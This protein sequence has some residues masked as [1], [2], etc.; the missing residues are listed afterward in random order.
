VSAQVTFDLGSTFWINRLALWNEESAGAGIVD[1]SYSLDGT[2]FLPLA[3][4]L[5]PTDHVALAGDPAA[6]VSLDPPPS[7]GADVFKFN[8]TFTRFV[9]FNM[10]QCGLGNDDFN[11]CAIG[12]VA[13]AEA[14]PVPEPATLLF[15]GSGL[16]GLA[17][18]RRRLTGRR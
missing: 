14:A 15:V 7:Y 8:P 6:G 16:A 2:T 9:R 12:E 17:L 3:L 4:G 13:F 10:S 5:I 18:R 11:G 1:L